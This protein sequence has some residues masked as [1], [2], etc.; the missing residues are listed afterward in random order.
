M[1]FLKWIGYALVSA[2]GLGAVVVVYLI[3]A[4]I[5]ATIGVVALGAFGIFFVTYLIKDYFDHRGS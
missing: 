5:G 2:L 1:E 3:L 4:A